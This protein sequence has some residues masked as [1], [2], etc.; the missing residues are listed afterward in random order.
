MV[1]QRTNTNFKGLDGFV[2]L[3]I[4][5]F[6]NARGSVNVTVQRLFLPVLLASVFY[7]TKVIVVLHHYDKKENNSLFYHFNFWLMLYLVRLNLNRLKVVVVADYWRNWLLQQGV[8]Q[9]SI[10]TVPNLFNNEVYTSLKTS[11]PKKQQIYLGQFGAKQHPIIFDLAKELTH[12]GYTCFFTTPHPHNQHISPN[13]SVKHLQFDDYLKELGA[14]LYTVCLSSFNE[15]WNRTA[16]ESL[17]LGTPVIGNNVGGLGQL[18][19]E[20]NQPM[21]STK[22]EVMALI[23]QKQNIHI[24]ETFLMR[25]HINQISYYAKPLEKFCSNG[26]S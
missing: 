4:Y 1:E 2:K 19:K 7:N 26:I 11:T 6:K 18:L 8:N 5:A 21:I 10:C 14:S 12:H 13:F 24:P 17:L 22:E 16:H 20:A 9:D 25:Y 15:G 3:W 23:L